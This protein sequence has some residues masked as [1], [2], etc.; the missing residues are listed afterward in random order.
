MAAR[1][2]EVLTF[3]KDMA[4]GVLKVSVSDDVDAVALEYRKSPGSAWS[5]SIAKTNPAGSRQVTLNVPP[6]LSKVETRVVVTKT[7]PAP[8]ALQYTKSAGDSSVS[9]AQTPAG[10]KVALEAFDS[11]WKT[12]KRVALAE[13]SKP[14]GGVRINVPKENRGSELRVVAVD[15]AN[16]STV[17]TKFPDLFRKGKTSFEG[18]EINNARFSASSTMLAANPAAISDVKTTDA[19]TV[20]EADIWRVLGKR[21]YFFNQLRGLQVI[22]TTNPAAPEI[23]SSLRM[24]AVGEDMYVLSANK[25]LL[26]R[27]DYSGNWKTYAVLIDCSEPTATIVNKVEIPGWYADSRMVNGRLVIATQSWNYSTF[28]Q[29]G[30]LSVVDDVATAPR[31]TESRQ[32]ESG[33]STMGAGP[34]YLWVAGSNWRNWSQSTLTLFRIDGLPS[35]GSPLS[36]NLQGTIQ[37]KFKVHQNGNALF[38]ITQSWGSNWRGVAKL[39]SFTLENGTATPAATLTLVEGESLHATRFDGNRAY[40]VTFRNVDPLWI[41]D[42]SEAADPKIVSELEV[43]GWS[44]YIQP[45][46]DCLA[47]VGVEGGKVVASLFDVSDPANPSLASRVEVGGDKEWTWSEANW[48][49]KAVAILPAENLI[50]LPYQSWR[51]GNGADSAVQIIDFNAAAKTLVKRG[52]VKHAFQPRRATAL[53]QGILA[54]ISNRELLLVDASDRDNPAILSDSTL[55]FGA[56]R[57][58]LANEKFLVHSED[59]AWGSG[60]ATLRVSDASNPEDLLAEVVLPGDRVVCGGANGNRLAIAALNTKS[61]GQSNLIVYQVDALPK[62]VE[63]G[64]SAADFSGVSIYGGRTDLLWPANDL[65]VVSSVGSGWGWDRPIA[66]GG[67]VRVA[68]CWLPGGWSPNDGIKLFPFDLSGA[69]PKACLP[70]DLSSQQFQNPSTLF[71][72]DG[73]IVFSAEKVEQKA[74]KKSGLAAQRLRIPMPV[75][76]PRTLVNSYL[77]VIDFADPSSPA[78]WPATS[79]PGKLEGIADFDRSAGIVITSSPKS[80]S[81]EKITALL[82][83]SGAASSIASFDLK[84]GQPKAVSGRAVYSA[85]GASLTLRTL[86]NNGLFTAKGSIAGLPWNPVELMADGNFVCFRNGQE[87]GLVDAPLVGDVSTWTLDSWLWWNLGDAR[88]FGDSLAIPLRDYGIEILR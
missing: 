81:G 54:S 68:A 14:G 22:D 16:P 59:G 64:R 73:L 61:P 88:L 44:S 56:D 32:F 10:K 23:V 87:I 58:L 57:I 46:D 34:D 53:E 79:I 27:R 76:L 51:W 20:E 25:V 15:P 45:V 9:V 72:A 21:L 63:S 38:A 70:F 18:R 17:S 60:H 47:A 55:A 12:W 13:A 69:S 52:I 75:E 84:A 3:R 28:D 39:E 82:F 2:G 41:L 78:L 62:L 35:L 65:A 80:D 42:I 8:A 83:E 7:R 33:L 48:N 6:N 77:A 4:N 74:L 29:T 85:D 1:V 40:A 30:V 86:E 37:D 50:L 5:R 67:D 19:N 36:V 31:V 49:E 71:A 24:P 26:V 11:G 66:F 43:P